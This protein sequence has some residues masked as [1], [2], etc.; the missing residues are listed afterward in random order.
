MGSYSQS[1]EP[2]G[3][4]GLQTKCY[5]L[6]LEV[7]WCVKALRQNEL[8]LKVSVCK[9]KIKNQRI[10]PWGTAIRLRRDQHRQQRGGSQ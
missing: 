9:K 10:D 2:G 4:Y 5:G 6:V 1:L 7:R 3:E 8:T